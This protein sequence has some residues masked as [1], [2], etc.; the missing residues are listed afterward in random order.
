MTY[1]SSGGGRTRP[2][3]SQPA[4]ADIILRVDKLQY[5]RGPPQASFVIRMPSSDPEVPYISVVAATQCGNSDS[6]RTFIDSW[7]RQSERLGLSL[8]LI[9]VARKVEYGATDYKIGEA[10]WKRH[11]FYRL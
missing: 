3:K 4:E 10:V 7:M 11:F 1:F 2:T 9:V 6:A 5:T 8:E